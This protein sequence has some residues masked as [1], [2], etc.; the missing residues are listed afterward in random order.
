MPEE[1]PFRRLSRS[2]S[3][4]AQSTTSQFRFHFLSVV[5]VH[6]VVVDDALTDK[7]YIRL[8]TDGSGALDRSPQI[9]S[10]Q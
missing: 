8:K 1:V 2:R 4:H 7:L 3:R 9:R 5:E 10:P 6:R